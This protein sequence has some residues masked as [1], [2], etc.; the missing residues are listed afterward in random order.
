MTENISSEPVELCRN[1]RT[2]M[3]YVMGRF[4]NES[5]E[6]SS[7]AQYWCLLSMQSFGLDGSYACPEQCRIGRCCYEDCQ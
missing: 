1:L 3:Y 2:K 7:T 4:H 5:G 6:S